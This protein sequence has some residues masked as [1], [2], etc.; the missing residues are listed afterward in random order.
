MIE[1]VMELSLKMFLIVCPL[2]FLAG[3]VDAIGGGGLISLPAYMLAGLPAK[4]AVS[5]NKLSASI[6]TFAS[7]ARYVKQGCVDWLTALPGV[8][9]ALIGAYCGA[10]IGLNLPDKVFEIALLVVLP[11]VAAYVLLHRELKKPDKPDLPR[12]RQIA[13]V[14]IVSLVIGFYDGFY[15]PGTGTFLIL[16]YTALARMDVLTAGGNTKLSNLA[17]NVMSITVFLF[18][19]TVLIPLG[20]TAAVFSIAGHFIGAGIA[21]KKGAKSIRFVIL[22][23]IALLF[24]KVIFEMLTK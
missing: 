15:G 23:V 7:T 2:V 11:V 3:V 17:S 21:L 8:A 14:C 18:N 13:V 12:A 19:G 24:A 1:A 6:G 16:L 20:L 4:L 5:T 10:N 22:I 9:M